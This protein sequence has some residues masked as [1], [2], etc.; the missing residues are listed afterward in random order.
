MNNQAHGPHYY[1]QGFQH[2]EGRPPPYSPYHGMYPAP[3][4]GPPSYADSQ[5]P[6]QTINTHHDSPGVPQNTGQKKGMKKSH[7]KHIVSA[8]VCVLVVL[9]VIAI[10]L[11]YFLYYQCLQGKLCGNGGVCLSASQWC[12]GVEDC[13]QG[14]DEA[15][16]LHCYGTNLILQ[17]YSSDS[18]TWKPVCAEGWND[19][20]GKAACEQMGY[21]GSQYMSFTQVS[22]GS[23]ASKGYM[24]LKPGHKP[25]ALIQS[26]LIHSQSCS[27]NA[28]SLHCIDCGVSDAAPSTRIVG[29]TMAAR[30][31]WPWQ[32]SLQINGHHLCGGS[33]ISAYWI[34]SAAHCFEEFSNPEIWIVYSGH[35]SLQAMSNRGTTVRKI[36]SHEKYDAATSD[37]DIALLKLN[38]PLTFS[39][40]VRPVCLP[41]VGVNLSPERLAWITGWGAQHSHGPT[42]DRLMQAQVTIYSRDNCNRQEVLNGEV[43]KTMICA[44][45][46]QGGVDACQGDSG[47]PLVTK[48]GGLWWLVGDTSW[49]YG[50]AL[51][52]KPGV[53]GNVTYFID[54]IYEQMKKE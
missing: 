24:K 33:I 38:T 31:A 25:G 18:Q 52:N 13:P 46:L 35:V 20:Y 28:V 15:N 50:C 49:G 10:L 39:R 23:L 34:V 30:G 42:T 36:I 1:N 32:V 37:N 4:Q 43:T 54:W 5:V 9:A 12:D 41:N 26:Q 47:G 19:N 2:E 17:S 53:Y 14:D 40:E 8:F 48:E 6:H 16:C 29:G 7:C 27:E 11:W 51:R 21:K 45:K 44:G 3:S 22:A